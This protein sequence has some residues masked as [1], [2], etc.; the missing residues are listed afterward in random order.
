MIARGWLRGG[1]VFLAVANG[2]IGLVQLAL[3]KVFYDDFPAPGH[4]WV[5]MV[6]PYSEH[7]MRDVGAL[8]LASVLVL[9]V[10]A[11]SMERVMVRTALAANLVFVVPHFVFHTVHLEH[12]PASDALAQTVVLSVGVALPCAL[13]ALTVQRNVTR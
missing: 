3:P 5:S 13:L 9:V 2:L 6:P 11:V 8:Q 7:L 1:L 10:A 4:P 12:F